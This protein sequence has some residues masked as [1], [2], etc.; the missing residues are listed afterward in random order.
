LQL[1]DRQVVEH[2]PVARTEAI[3]SNANLGSKRIITPASSI[4]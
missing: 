1:A 4:I 2:Q 3:S